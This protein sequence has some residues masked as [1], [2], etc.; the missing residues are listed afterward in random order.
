MLST[1][2]PRV[3]TLHPTPCY[4]FSNSACDTLDLT[5]DLAHLIP[6]PLPLTTH[7]SPN[8]EPS[9]GRRQVRHLHTHDYPQFVR[10]ESLG[11]LV[12]EERGWITP[13]LLTLSLFL[14][15]LFF[16]SA[17]TQ[18]QH[19]THFINT[20]TN[21]RRPAMLTSSRGICHFGRLLFAALDL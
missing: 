2:R 10:K 12:Q 1:C 20:L 11:G 4:P 9:E 18:L 15:F 16:H 14:F 13:S 8:C 21:G 17:G 5:T 6:L 19:P 7:V 3:Q